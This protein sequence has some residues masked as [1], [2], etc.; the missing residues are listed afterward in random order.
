MR[1]LLTGTTTKLTA[2]AIFTCAAVAAVVTYVPQFSS[3]KLSLSPNSSFSSAVSSAPP[4]CED[5]IFV[6]CI[7]Q[8]ASISIPLAGSA[9]YL[10]YSSDR[11]TGPTNNASSGTQHFGLAGWAINVLHAY[12]VKEHVLTFGSG[13][14]RRVDAL[15][16]RLNG[17][18]ALAVPSLEAT[19]IYVFDA[20]GRHLQTIDGVT[21]FALLKFQWSDAGL[22]SISEI[23]DHTTRILRDDKGVPTSIIS[24]RGYR[25]RLGVKDGWLVAV[26]TPSDHISRITTSPQ[27]LVTEFRNATNARTSLRYDSQGKLTAIQGP[28]G[29]SLTLKGSGSANNS[30][31]TV[32]TGGGR[33]WT[34]SVKSEGTRVVRTYTDAAGIHTNVEIEGNKRVLKTPDGTIYRFTLQA[35]PQWGTAAWIPAVEAQTPAGLRWTITE[36]RKGGPVKHQLQPQTHE[37]TLTVDGAAWTLSYEPSSRKI[38][39]H[40]PEGGSRTTTLNDKGQTLRID[41][42]GFAP[43]LYAY[44]SQSR[45]KSITHGEGAD[46]RQWRYEFNPAERTVTSIDPLGKKRVLSFDQSG[47]ATALTTPEGNKVVAEWNELEQ[48]TAFSP[49]GRTATRWNYRDDGL[50]DMMTLPAGADGLSLTTY[51]YDKDG[52]VTEVKQA[53]GN[54]VMVKRDDAGRIKN[55]QTHPGSWRAE[56]DPKTGLKTQLE[57]A[58]ETVT[59]A[60]DGSQPISETWS[61]MVNA[62]ITRQFDGQGRVVA[63]DIADS[64]K[65]EYQYDKAG[66]LIQAG[67]LTISRHPSTGQVQSER[68]GTLERTWRYNS[69]GEIV[70]AAI[71]ASGKSIYKLSVQRDKLGRVTERTEQFSNGKTHKRTFSYDKEDRLAS[72]QDNDGPITRYAYDANGNLVRES[73]PGK[74]IEATYDGQDKLIRRG[75]DLY[76]YNPAGQLATSTT[77]SGKTFYEYDRAGRLIAVTLPSGDKVSYAIDGEGRRIGRSV[78]GKLAETYVYSD[79]LRLAAE[80]DAN[81]TLVNRFVYAQSTTT[82]TYFTKEGKSYLIVTDDIGTPRLLIDANAGTMVEKFEFD[83]WGRIEVASNS[84]VVKFGLAGGLADHDTQLVHFGVRDYSPVAARW[85]APDPVEFGGGDSNLYRYSSD[86]PINRIDPLGTCD[87]GT[88]GLSYGAFVASATAGV[89][90]SGASGHVDAGLFFTLGKGAGIGAGPSLQAGCL[91]EQGEKIPAHPVKQIEGGGRTVDVTVGV[92][93]GYD[94]SYSD[95]GSKSLQGGHSS[96]GGAGAVVH[97][98]GT[99][100]WCWTCDDGP[101]RPPQPLPPPHPCWLNVAN[102]PEILRQQDRQAEAKELADKMFPGLHMPE[103]PDEYARRK[104][105]ESVF[106]WGDPHLSTADGFRYDFMAVGEFTAL[107]SDKGDMVVQ[108][109]QVPWLG[110]RWV[111]MNNAAAIKVNKDRL[112]IQFEQQSLIL[113]VNGARTNLQSQLQLSGGGFIVSDG[114][115]YRIGWPDG[116]SLRVSRHVW[117]LDLAMRLAEGRKGTVSG[118]LGPFT[119]KHADAIVTKAGTSIKSDQINYQRLYREYG[120]SWRITQAES[121]F[122]YEPGKSIAS[123]DDRTFPDPNPPKIPVATENSAR[124]ICERAGVPKQALAG[125]ILDVS[126]TGEAGFAMTTAAALRPLASPMLVER[127]APSTKDQPNGQTFPIKI[128]D[129]VSVDKPGKGA[130]RI[131]MAGAVDEYTFTAR[132]GTPVYLKG[133]PPC[134][135]NEVVWE[136]YNP[137]NTYVG[138]SRVCDDIGRKVLEQD[139]TYTI[140]VFGKSTAFG[141]Y[142]FAL[143]PVAADQT[144]PLKIG[145]HVSVDKPGKGAGRIEMAGAVDEY[146]FTARAGTPVYLKGEPPCTN[147]EVVWELY[148][149]TNTYVGGSRVCDDI[150]RKVLEQDGTYTIKVFGKSTAFGDYGFAIQT[151]R[152]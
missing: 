57:G 141:D 98:T 100:V 110:L 41:Q 93:G 73:S 107:R 109:R 127:T 152:R 38:A 102:C 59:F 142:G 16:V 67:E 6:P 147:N 139:G 4:E 105:T 33:S 129:H 10:T 101:V 46:A 22:L 92:G 82:P 94:E 112:T 145:D 53:D 47:H 81:G 132:A 120:D 43:L 118:L 123:Y 84:R 40:T 13:A 15:S 25:T 151:D 77:N 50:V 63:E 51:G 124:A 64:S 126:V 35:D 122:D 17:A 96:F 106:S 144:F 138:G 108:V 85:T 148:N 72:V 2:A 90:Y 137:T 128:G 70:G 62:K 1:G 69:F 27:G 149:P 20:Q 71:T 9:F 45:L 119:G 37:R 14:K 75:T 135:N 95:N 113:R 80:L 115:N 76:E 12:D 8:A 103:T 68:L 150:G 143:L 131:E 86:D 87:V 48:V 88:L 32:T 60:Y 7:R 42:V 78:D 134:T 116:S 133:E 89:V 44:D 24:A 30:S 23:G 146:T 99:V 136:L 39:V 61:G 74:T 130:G 104:F 34:H 117:G 26:A 121:L 36:T 125:C 18:P 29:S 79:L 3:E 91:F 21:G 11:T 49:P 66:R 56:Y 114:P 19:E 5:F 140:K 65:I 54:G 55:V 111:S 97:D 58:G 52:L 28:T 83:P 31:T